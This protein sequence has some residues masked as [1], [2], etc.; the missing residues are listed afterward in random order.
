MKTLSLTS[1]GFLSFVCLK[2]NFENITSH[3]YIYFGYAAYHLV[4]IICRVRDPDM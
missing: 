3:F 2:K 4:I 1:L